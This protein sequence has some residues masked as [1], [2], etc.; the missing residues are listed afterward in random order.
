MIRLGY[1][2]FSVAFALAATSVTLLAGEN[3][4]IPEYIWLMISLSAI[5]ALLAIAWREK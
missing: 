3:A 5:T 2:I 4:K 1:S